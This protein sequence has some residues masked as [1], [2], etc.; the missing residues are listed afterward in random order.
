MRD[1]IFLDTNILVYSLLDND[2]PKHAQALKLMEALKGNYLFISTQVVNELYVT[3]LKHGLEEKEVDARIKKVIEIYNIP[4]TTVLTLK[5]GWS[6][7]KK[8]KLS[9]WDCIILASAL[10]SDC[11]IIYT[12]DMQD[13]LKV[14]G[15]LEVINPFTAGGRL[16]SSRLPADQPSKPEKQYKSE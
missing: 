6:I 7:R 1:R 13:G 8:Y 15:K 5:T 9:Y 10:E 4:F 14:E 2:E 11:A 16:K 3:L 12:E